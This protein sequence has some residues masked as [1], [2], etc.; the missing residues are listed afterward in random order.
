[1][2]PG[3]QEESKTNDQNKIITNDSD[4]ELINAQVYSLKKIFNARDLKNVM[5]HSK[6]INK[7]FDNI[8][9]KIKNGLLDII[10]NNFSKKMHN[11]LEN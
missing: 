5:N 1:M 7:D 2:T 4:G 8:S 3:Q 11:H 10:N 9:Y 6:L